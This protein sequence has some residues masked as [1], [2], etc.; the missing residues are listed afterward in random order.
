MALNHEIK[1]GYWMQQ[2][3]LHILQ[4]SVVQIELYVFVL[5]GVKNADMITICLMQ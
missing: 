4:E 2:L 3:N 5:V 1:I